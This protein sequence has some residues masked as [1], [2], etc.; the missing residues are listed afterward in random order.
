MADASLR[1][2][3]CRSKVG[4]DAIDEPRTNRML[5]TSGRGWGEGLCHRNKRTSRGLDVQ[6]SSPVRLAAVGEVCVVAT[7]PGS[8]GRDWYHFLQV[9]PLFV[10]FFSHGQLEPR[11]W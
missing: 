6:C 1:P 5:P 10:V 2:G 9:L 11:L 8:P 4:W 3:T 7:S